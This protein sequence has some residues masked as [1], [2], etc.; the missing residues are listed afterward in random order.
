MNDNAD[1]A[2][3]ALDAATDSAFPV[4]SYGGQPAHVV[5]SFG[6][7]GAFYDIN[8]SGV[9]VGTTSDANG[10]DHAF[11]YDHG[12][13]IDYGPNTST[14]GIN[15]SGVIAL[16]RGND[17]LLASPDGT[18]FPLQRGAYTKAEAL[19]ISNRGGAV[20]IVYPAANIQVPKPAA[21]TPSGLLRPLPLPPGYSV[22]YAYFISPGDTL[23]AGLVEVNPGSN[24]VGVVWDGDT[25]Q[26]LPTAPGLESIPQ[27]V[28][29]DNVVVGLEYDPATNGE[30]SV[31]WNGSQTIDIAQRSTPQSTTDFPVM[32]ALS[33]NYTMAGTS[34]Q[35]FTGT[36]AKP[37]SGMLARVST[38]RLKLPLVPPVH[39]DVP[40]KGTPLHGMLEIF[41]THRLI[42]L[43][44][45]GGLPLGLP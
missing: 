35:T 34:A 2:G 15:D 4:I 30:T 18:E 44:T 24:P 8:A 1:A 17:A 21:W 27:G 13:R 6:L 11:A 14:R 37:Q 45:I 16:N 42:T 31:L 12:Q 19:N 10:M 20:G 5:D 7:S 29:D 43:P 36:I 9:A 25:V 33:N 41:G 38:R 28:N 22:G 26:F 23:V 32:F 40:I 39:F 3:V